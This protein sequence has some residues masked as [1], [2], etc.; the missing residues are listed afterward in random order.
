MAVKRLPRGRWPVA[1]RAVSGKAKSMPPATS[2]NFIAE[3]AHSISRVMATPGETTAAHLLAYPGLRRVPTAKV[4]IFDR[5][6]FLPPDLCGEL[7]ALIDRDRRPS[8]IADPN[9]D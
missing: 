1:Q 6:G 4:E 3:P 8:T 2:R 9:G 7:I 5:P